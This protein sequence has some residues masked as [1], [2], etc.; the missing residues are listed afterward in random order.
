MQNKYTE[1]GS[2]E[3]LCDLCSFPYEYLK[4][5]TVDQR[6]I[7]ISDFENLWTVK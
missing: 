5:L 7:L 3:Y 6:L 2:L 1:Q 4:A